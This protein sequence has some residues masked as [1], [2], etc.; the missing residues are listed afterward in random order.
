MGR[1]NK[2]NTRRILSPM[3]VPRV[4]LAAAFHPK[5]K[6]TFREVLVI[7]CWYV[8][9]ERVAEMTC[10]CIASWILRHHG[11]VS[12]FVVLSSGGKNCMAVGRRGSPGRP[13]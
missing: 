6:T 5:D 7:L 11:E 3:C 1:S 10:V 4:G 9:A 12:R 8:M 13:R 2:R